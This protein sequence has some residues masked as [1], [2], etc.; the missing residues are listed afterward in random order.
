MFED[1]TYYIENGELY[2]K[3]INDTVA[4]KLRAIESDK[5]ILL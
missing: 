4:L 2:C 3:E 1:E 5:W